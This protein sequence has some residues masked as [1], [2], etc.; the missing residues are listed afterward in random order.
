MDD[1][2]ISQDLQIYN[3]L[4][5]ILPFEVICNWITY[6]EPQLLNKFINNQYERLNEYENSNYYLMTKGGQYK[7]LNGREDDY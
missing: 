7:R 2:L 3:K 1:I 4:S 6:D 5:D